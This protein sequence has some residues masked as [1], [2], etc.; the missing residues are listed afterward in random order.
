MTLLHIT[1]NGDLSSVAREHLDRAS[2]TLRGLDI[3]G[4]VRIRQAA[5]PAEGIV[6]EAGEGKHD[7]IVVGGHGPRVRSL[8]KFDD[9][10]FQVL[11]GVDRS[12]LVVPVE[13][14]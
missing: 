4:A 11:N 10:T 13:E 14:E 9:V 6:A 2:A 7:L 8:F 1:G 3:S 5:T 12:V